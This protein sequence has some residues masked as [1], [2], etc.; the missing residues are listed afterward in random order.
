MPYLTPVAYR[1]LADVGGDL[2]AA[3]TS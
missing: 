2:R 1:A 3:L